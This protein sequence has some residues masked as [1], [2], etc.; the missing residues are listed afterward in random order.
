[1]V[2]RSD[3][4]PGRFGGNGTGS[5]DWPGAVAELVPNAEITGIDGDPAWLKTC[6]PRYGSVVTTAIE[7]LA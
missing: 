2:A 4:D 6:W 7:R 1:M 3:V 5:G